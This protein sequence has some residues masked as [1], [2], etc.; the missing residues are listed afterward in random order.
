MGHSLSHI[1]DLQVRLFA[2]D[3]LLLCPVFFFKLIYGKPY[4]GIYPNIAELLYMH[5]NFAVIRLGNSSG[6]A[7]ERVSVSTE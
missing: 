2:Y 3:P 7:G 5:G 4:R 6:Y 1:S